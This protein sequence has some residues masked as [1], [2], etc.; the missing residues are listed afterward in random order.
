MQMLSMDEFSHVKLKM[1][2]FF[3]E[4][5]TSASFQLTHFNFILDVMEEEVERHFGFATGTRPDTRPK[6]VADG[7]AGAR[8]RGFTL[9]DR[10][11]TI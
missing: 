2:F 8:T 7:W 10:F 3:G 4:N 9:S 5:D 1:L 6:P 11:H